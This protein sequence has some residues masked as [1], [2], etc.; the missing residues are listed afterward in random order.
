[1]ETLVV[2]HF[3]KYKN[4]IIENRKMF[5]KNR[6]YIESL[7]WAIALCGLYALPIQEGPSLCLFKWAGFSHCPGC[8]LGHAIHHA[9]HFEFALSWQD[10]I[11]GIPATVILLIQVAKPFFKNK[12]H[13]YGPANAYDVERIAAR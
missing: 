11:L 10:H 8:G 5:L 3:N 7:I 9:L 2:R 1:M 6:K 12:T 13:S 4:W